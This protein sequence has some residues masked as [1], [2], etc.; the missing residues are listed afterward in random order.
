MAIAGA[1]AIAVALLASTVLR[2]PSTSPPAGPVLHMSLLS[3]ERVTRAET[4]AIR[5]SASTARARRER[6]AC[7]CKSKSKTFR[8]V[9]AAFRPT[10]QIR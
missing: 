5:R 4:S 7:R 10:Q 3:P 6:V 9:F 2:A 1:L 8:E